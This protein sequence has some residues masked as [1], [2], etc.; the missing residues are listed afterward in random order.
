[1][2]AMALAGSGVRS[3]GAE[4]WVSWHTD[5]LL[6]HRDGVQPGLVKCCLENG[7]ELG[8][9]LAHVCWRLLFGR[10]DRLSTIYLSVLVCASAG[11]KAGSLT[12]RLNVASSR[13]WTSA[14]KADASR[15]VTRSLLKAQDL[16]GERSRFCF[17]VSMASAYQI[18][19]ALTKEPCWTD[20]LCLAF[21]RSRNE[22]IEEWSRRMCVRQL[23]RMSI[24]DMLCRCR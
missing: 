21:Q 20:N 3:T 18:A 6:T 14:M 11:S 1:M 13:G 16:P 10:H 8:S 7:A 23:C 4:S 19:S 17:A 22:V 12:W 24:Y 2:R 15:V 9:S 5:G